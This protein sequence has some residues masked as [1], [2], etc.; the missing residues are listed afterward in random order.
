MRP[1]IQ[2]RNFIEG[3]GSEN[4]PR[5]K[6]L[7]L[8]MGAPRRSAR[9]PPTCKE[10]PVWTRPG[11]PTPCIPSPLTR[12]PPARGPSDGAAHL[13]GLGPGCPRRAGQQDRAH[14]THPRSSCGV[15]AAAV[16]T[17]LFSID[18]CHLGRFDTA[19]S[20]G[21][22]VSHIRKVGMALLVAALGLTACAGQSD[23]ERCKAGGGVWKQ[24]SCEN[25]S[26]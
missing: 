23:E 15:R 20:G 26:R 1:A 6:R 24:N 5:D 9:L 12:R 13:P 14:A 2:P 8:S 17:C 10:T 19:S 18:P 25:S 16:A 22:P 11:C 7:A 3:K 21:M 4:R